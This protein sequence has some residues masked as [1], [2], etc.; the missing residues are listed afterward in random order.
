MS[1]LALLVA[2]AVAASAPTEPGVE[3]FL[4]RTLPTQATGTA[5]VVRDGK[6]VHCAGFT[7]ATG[8][9]TVYD[10]MSM[11]KQFTAA[12]IL[13]LET[14]GRLR[15]SDPISRYVGPV[16]A[17]K[18]RITLRMLLTHTSGLPAALGDDYDVLSRDQMLAEAMAAPLQAPPGR[19][20]HYSNV[21]YSVLAAIVERTSGIS[22]ERFLA[23]HLL[24][25]AGMTQTGYV[26]PRWRRERVAVEYD[27]RG[28]PHGRPFD[29]PWAE[30]GPYWN[31]RGNGGLLSTAR[32][33][34]RWQRGLDGDAVLSRREKRKL[35][36]PRVPI[37]VEGYEG[38]R[39]GYGWAVGH[40][41][42]THSGGNG[43]SYGV[44]ARFVDERTT[45]FWISNRAASARRWDLHALARRLTLGIQRS[46]AGGSSARIR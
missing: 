13:K 16:P 25:P 31:L 2:A 37:P 23:R 34:A 19:E 18:R 15:V 24:A 33:M 41:I 5:A 38:F 21:G 20:F 45:V 46:L 35:F 6:L 9:D 39:A 44:V 4:D 22:Y 12:A 40:G 11:T 36:R 1:A 8:C 14:M 30:D 32:D 28:R 29:H 7:R 10:L 17:D 3:R 27:R 42:A 26:L 43:W